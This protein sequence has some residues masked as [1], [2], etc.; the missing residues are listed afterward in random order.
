MKYILPLLSIAFLFNACRSKHEVDTSEVNISLEVID[1]SKAIMDSTLNKGGTQFDELLS[2]HPEFMKVYVEEIFQLGNIEDSAAVNE[3]LYYLVSAPEM[4]ALYSQTKTTFSEQIVENLEIAFKYLKYHFPEMPLPKIY[5]HLGRFQYAA[6]S[7]SNYLAIASEMTLGMSNQYMKT[8]GLPQ[9]V[10]RKLDNKHMPIHAMQSHLLSTFAQVKKEQL[11][12]YMIYNGK[13]L[14]ALDACFPSSADSLKIGYQKGKIEWCYN[15]QDQ[16]WA[17]LLKHNLL[18][19]TQQ[20]EFLKFTTDGPNTAGMPPEAP[21]NI[22]SWVG[23]QIVRAYME[24]HPK[25]TL[26]E[27]FTKPG[28][29]QSQVLL[30]KSGYKPN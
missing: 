4:Q 17:W 3:A 23:W 18:Y 27:L 30:S 20:M 15:N 24:T 7:G 21:G 8:S 26:K 13:I 19:S 10:C 28:L 22:A 6:F 25:T 12:D 16:I 14:Y 2:K 1:M 29:Q 11:I 5:K 9:Y